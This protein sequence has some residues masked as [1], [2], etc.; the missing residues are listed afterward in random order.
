[1]LA[2]G[3]HQAP[4][5][6]ETSE[7]IVLV[8]DQAVV[9]VAQSERGRQ[10]GPGMPSVLAE[11][12][13]FCACA[14]DVAGKA[15]HPNRWNAQE[16]VGDTIAKAATGRRARGKKSALDAGRQRPKD[17]VTRENSAKLVLI[18]RI[19]ILKEIPALDGPDVH[20]QIPGMAAAHQGQGFSVLKGID[21]AGL[22]DAG[23]GAHAVV[24][25]EAQVGHSGIA[26]GGRRAR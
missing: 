12:V 26:R 8:R 15:A 16:C 7:V 24:S 3:K 2:R 21:G 19:N 22:R 9:F 6:I 10:V 5:E 13:V 14:G 25:R 17:C 11:R 23:V 4:I 20:A 18:A 1:M